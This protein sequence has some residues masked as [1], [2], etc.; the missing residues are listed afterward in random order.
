M[1]FMDL[2]LVQLAF[3][4][5]HAEDVPGMRILVVCESLR[6]R[7]RSVVLQRA[8]PHRPKRALKG[9]DLADLG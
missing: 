3:L 4:V 7:E 9:R 8:G 1:S 5:Q 6:G 2:E